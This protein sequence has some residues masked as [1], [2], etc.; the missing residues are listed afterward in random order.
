M[1]SSS[2]GRA[3]SAR[4]AVNQ[5]AVGV[6]YNK[7]LAAKIGMTAPPKTVEEFDALL[8]KAKDAGLQPIMQWN[9]ATS[10]GGLAFPL[11]NLM[12]AYG[13]HSAI[14]DWV[15]LKEGATVDTPE[16][17]QA[18]QKLDEWIK[19]GYFPSDVNA[20]EYTD[21][22]GRF[23]KGEGVFTFNGDWQNGGYDKDLPGKVGFFTFPENVGMS[24]GLTFVVASEVEARGLR[25]LLP[26]LG[27]HQRQGARD[28]RG[29]RRLQPRWPGRREG[30]GS[31][32]RLRD[33]A[34][35]RGR[36]RCHRQQRRHGLHRQRHERDLLRELDA[37]SPEAGRR[38]DHPRAA[39]Q[40]C[41]GLLDEGPV[42]RRRPDADGQLA[43]DVRA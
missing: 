22:A 36:R 24:A 4:S 38:E 1:T 33:G 37:G 23:G 20:I 39:P 34:D 35:A 6:F 13:D 14:N 3:R 10:G 41:P 43:A 27:R 5:S 17:V 21:A 26:Q 11:Q 8:A 9:A 25:R 12:A 30:P 2:G 19:K 29:R 16:F 18:A 31:R 32:R 42:G 40:E 7:D 28:Q 15:F